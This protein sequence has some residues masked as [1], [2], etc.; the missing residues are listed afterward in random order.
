MIHTPVITPSFKL[1]AP[2]LPQSNKHGIGASAAADLR[3]HIDPYPEMDSGDLIELFWGGCYAASKL[4]SESDIGHT[5]VLHVPESFLRSGKVK[6]Y[7]RVTKIGSTPIK[8]PGTKLWVKLETPGGQLVSGEVDENQGLAPV[9]FEEAVIS[10]GLTARH[11]DEGVQ[12]TLDIYP[13][14]D[15][16]DEI[17]LRWGD[18]RLDL[19]ALTQQDVDKPVVV[20]VPAELVR[21]AGDDPHLE[22]S[23]CVIDRVGNNSRWAPVRLI[24][25]SL[26]DPSQAEA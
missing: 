21:E 1:I 8:S 7:Y 9:A 2:Y 10:N 19:P 26:N 23:Y 5:S 3:V 17:T 13:H 11:F 4:L 6:T 18:I 25:V 14:M 12:I 24:K 16:H 15:A 22:V 20:Q